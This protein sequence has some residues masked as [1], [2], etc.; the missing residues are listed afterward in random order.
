MNKM[1]GLAKTLITIIGVYWLIMIGLHGLQMISV[2]H[3]TMKN[4]KGE[5]ET[6]FGVVIIYLIFLIIALI[7][8][9]IL[10]S[11]DKIAI[12]IAGSEEFA[13][14]DA[15][16]KWIPFAFRLTSIIAGMYCMVRVVSYIPRIAGN[17]IV[18]EVNARGSGIRIEEFATV[19]IAGIYLLYGAPHFVNWQAK[20][21]METCTEKS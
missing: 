11:R 12:K 5:L 13:N 9:K 17:Y 4:I 18:K 1:Q 16:V 2:F 6:I 20:K 8:I 21:T 19:L 3:S 7:L 15:Q 10:R 14:V